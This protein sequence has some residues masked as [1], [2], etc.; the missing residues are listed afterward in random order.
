M[1]HA[2]EECIKRCNRQ[3][4]RQQGD[5]S[6]LRDNYDKMQ[7]EW[8]IGQ[9]I[10]LVYATILTKVQPA[11]AARDKQTT[12]P[13]CPQSVPHLFWT[14]NFSKWDN[15]IHTCSHEYQISVQY[16]ISHNISH[17][18]RKKHIQTPVDDNHTAESTT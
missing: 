8:H 5:N 12:Q 15:Q 3:S 16:I 2:T 17:P 7:K 11:M 4:I 14:S 18:Q 10:N 1:E 13:P 6:K 9:H